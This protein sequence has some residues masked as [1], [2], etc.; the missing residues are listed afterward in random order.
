MKRVILIRA[1]RTDWADQERLAGDMDLQINEAGRAE[2]AVSANEIA[3]L[4]PKSIFCGTD[5]PAIET[6]A[7][8]AAALGIKYKAIDELRELD[9]GLWEGLTEEQFK[10]RF[11]R[12]HKAWHDDPNS[13][14]P[15]TG[16]ALPVVDARIEKGIH[17]VT[18]RRAASPIVLVLGR[19]AY[20]ATR[21]RYADG[22]H[23]HYWDYVESPVTQCTLDVTADGIKPT[24]PPSS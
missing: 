21:C 12:V 9:L 4:S 6:A 3:S 2:A 11:S 15:P 1:G 22:T 19:L 17:S 7:I 5:E 10:E 14:E 8:I 18:K 13:V 16:E 20:A 24:I 23:E